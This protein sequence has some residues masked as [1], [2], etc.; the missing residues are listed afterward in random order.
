MA[1][2]VR[3][4]GLDDFQKE[5]KD[6][7]LM[8]KHKLKEAIQI[9]AIELTTDVKRQITDNRSVITGNLRNSVRML[10]RSLDGLGVEVG[11]DVVY[12]GSVDKRKPFFD[13]PVE[14]AS[15]NFQ[16]RLKDII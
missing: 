8:K 7:G 14:R 6:F 12:A 13:A 1:R 4:E 15:E 2:T 5:I 16:K 3:L 9:T 11:T 10:S